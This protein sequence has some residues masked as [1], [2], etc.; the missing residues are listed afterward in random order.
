MDIS[1]IKLPPDMVDTLDAIFQKAK[2]HN[3]GLTESLFLESIIREWLEPYRWGR[4]HVVLS[5]DRVRLRNNLRQAI[6]L[7]GK[8]QALIAR[9]IGVNRPYLSQVVSGKYEPSVTLALLLTEALGYP[10][11]KFKDLFFLE[12]VD[13]V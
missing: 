1:R 3:P 11:E 6:R 10:R 9:E 5:R 2:E 7:S 13:Q 8:S 12:P 4:N